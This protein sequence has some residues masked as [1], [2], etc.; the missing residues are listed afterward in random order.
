MPAQ[1]KPRCI[2]GRIVRLAFRERST[3]KVR[4]SNVVYPWRWTK[5][6][7]LASAREN[8]PDETVRIVEWCPYSKDQAWEPDVWIVSPHK[9]I[10][11]SVEGKRMV[12]IGGDQP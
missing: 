3:R 5:A 8:H 7:V 1:S 6:S 2:P 11:Y 4:E 10:D 9:I 12:R